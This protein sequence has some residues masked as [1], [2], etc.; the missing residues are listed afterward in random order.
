MLTTATG[1]WGP[2]CPPLLGPLGLAGHPRRAI[3]FYIPKKFGCAGHMGSPDSPW[4]QP[5]YPPLSP[6][7]SPGPKKIKKKPAPHTI[8]RHGEAP[9]SSSTSSEYCGRP[10]G[11]LHPTPVIGAL[12]GGRSGPNANANPH[13]SPRNATQR[14]ARVFADPESVRWGYV[15]S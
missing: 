4:F 8:P 10:E 2:V 9:S 14:S 11:R 5:A 3:S 15:Q 1:S 12:R 7:L 6:P 13:G